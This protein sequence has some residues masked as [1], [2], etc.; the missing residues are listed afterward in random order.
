MTAWS[1]ED[2]LPRQQQ[3]QL[4]QYL[5]PQQPQLKHQP[6][7]QILQVVNDRRV[8]LRAGSDTVLIVVW[9]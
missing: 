7:P 6:L 3:L 2:S 5:L 9:L 8:Y 1:C 4:S